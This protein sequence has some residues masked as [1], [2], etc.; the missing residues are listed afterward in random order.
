MQLHGNMPAHYLACF[1]LVSAFFHLPPQVLPSIQM[2]EGGRP[3]LAAANKDGSADLGVMQINTL[4]I[5]PL[6][7]YTRQPDSTIRH[8]LL[9]DPCFNIAAAGAIMRIYL[10][11]EKGNLMRAIGSYHSHKPARNQ[12][13]QLKV[14]E[15]S[16][17]LFRRRSERSF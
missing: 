6:A 8:R 5:A 13:Y 3:G 16:G 15:A 7:R 9:E 14:V 12:L 1:A 11:D 10:N 4:W 2:V 17:R